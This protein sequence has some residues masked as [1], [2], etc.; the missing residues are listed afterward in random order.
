MPEQPKSASA[1]ATILIAKDDE[2]MKAKIASLEAQIA[3]LQTAKTATDKDNEDL[4]AK[5]ASLEGK[6]GSTDDES[7]KVQDAKIAK[8]EG[9]ISQDYISKI[10]TAKK[11]QGFSEEELKAE[12]TR[13]TAMALEAVESEY[14]NNERH[15]TSLIAKSQEQENQSAMFAREEQAF[16]FNGGDSALTGKAISIDSILSGGKQQ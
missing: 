2:D 3:S 6:K 9:R 13:L 15:I 1:P 16:P 12:N 10:L 14:K 11:I 4:K 7:K 5:I 8:L